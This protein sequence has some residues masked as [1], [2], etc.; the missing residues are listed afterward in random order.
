MEDKLVPVL[1]N[2]RNG[3]PRSI[4]V[5]DNAEIHNDCADLIEQAT[6][7]H[8]AK[9]VYTAPYSPDLNPIELFFN[10]YKKGLKRFRDEPWEVAH[11]SSLYC[12]TPAMA[13]AFFKKSRCPL[14]SHFP[15]ASDIDD[16]YERR[17]R[18]VVLAAV[19]VTTVLDDDN[20][21]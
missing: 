8:C 4:V 15:S 10:E 13:K 19:A 20:E 9:L 1:G 14:S 11:L 18:A 2:F 6:G 5:C 16:E 7:A 3:E 21:E 17:Q 12:V